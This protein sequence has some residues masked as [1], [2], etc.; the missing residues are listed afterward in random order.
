MKLS[1]EEHTH[2]SQLEDNINYKFK[3]ISL[4]KEA[5]SHPSLKQHDINIKDYERLEL[6]GDSLL[7]FIIS[8]MIFSNFSHYQ[9]G[10][11]AK[12]K[13]YAVSKDTIVRIA[14]TLDLAHYIIMTEGEEKSH[15]RENPNNLENV[16]EALIAA[17]YL[18]AGIIKTK[19]FVHK[20]W[21]EYIHDLD[22]NAID[23]KS[24]LQELTQHLYH[25]TPSYK[26]IEKSGPMHSPIFTVQV[27]ASSHSQIAHGKTI[28]EAE[29]EAALKL[30][31]VLSNK[32]TE[33]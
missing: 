24:A 9:E 18:D 21:Y 30:L 28:K 31:Q 13:A 23:P 3:D 32:V 33:H 19:E 27:C 16:M 5:L 2:L 29:K 12:I 10:Q 8:E 11:I 17:I 20:L 26:V 15:G 22:F 6:L 7:G 25:N 1:M 14:K 4:L